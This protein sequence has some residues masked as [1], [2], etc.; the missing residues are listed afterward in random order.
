MTTAQQQQKHC[1]HIFNA[2]I[3]CDGEISGVIMGGSLNMHDKAE[4]AILKV[5]IIDLV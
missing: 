2:V 5:K 3:G 4:K 1:S